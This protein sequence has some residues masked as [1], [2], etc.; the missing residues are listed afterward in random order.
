[1][2]VAYN[3]RSAF[4]HG[5]QELSRGFR[6]ADDLGVPYLRTFRKN[7]SG[8]MERE[9]TIGL[10]WFSYI[11]RTALCK[12]LEMNQKGVSPQT[13]K[14]EV[15]REM[16]LKRSTTGM[17]INAGRLSPIYVGRICELRPQDVDFE[18]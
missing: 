13:V 3:V 6:N 10:R 11:V 12:Y 18:S 5:D 4:V 2:I 16:A 17:K 9:R 1:L 7:S 15:F 8:K 14:W